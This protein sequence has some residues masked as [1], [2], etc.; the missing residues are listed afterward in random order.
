ML[1]KIVNQAD[2]KL[3]EKQLRILERLKKTP[4]TVSVA[5]LLLQPKTLDTLGEPLRL[6]LAAGKNLD[7]AKY[8]VT[9]ADRSTVLSWGGNSTL[10]ISGEFISGLIYTNKEVFELRPLGD[11]LHA[12][13]TLDQS[14]YKDEPKDKK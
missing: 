6:P 3:T 8:T 9:K 1:F 10:S 2:L 5:L 4:A 13:A 14:K 12:L 7:I 11:G